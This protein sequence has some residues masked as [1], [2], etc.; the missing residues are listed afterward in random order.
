MRAGLEAR[1]HDPLWMLARQWQLGEFLGTDGGSPVIARFRAEASRLDR[2]LRGWPAGDA[3]SAAGEYRSR[4]FPLEALVEREQV[5]NG[6][7]PVLRLAAE[8]GLHFLRLLKRQGANEATR[9]AFVKGYPLRKPTEDQLD[10]DTARFRDVI[11]G[12]V[13]DAIALYVAMRQAGNPGEGALSGLP[14]ELQVKQPAE[15]SRVAHAADE[16]ISWYGNLFS[17]PGDERSAWIPER[18][19]YGFAVSARTAEGEVVLA[20]REY[21][22]GHLD[23][24]S[25]NLE[26]AASLGTS[27][28]SEREP[29]VAT[30]IPAPVGFRGMP[31]ARWWEFEDAQIDLG[32]VEAEPEDVARLLLVEFAIIYGNDWFVMPVE[33]PVGSI[34]RPRSL[35]VIDT[36]GQRT[37]IRPYTQVDGVESPWRVFH[38]SPDFFFLPPSLAASLQSPP[39]EEV[40]LMRDEMANMAWAVERVIESPAGR[41]VRRFEEFQQERELQRRERERAGAPGQP[42]SGLSLAYR[43]ASSV[44]PHWIPLMPERVDER[45]IRLRRGTVMQPDGSPAPIRPKGRILEPD[46]ALGLFEEEVSRAGVRITR[47]YQYA[48]W[49]DGTSHL[50]VARRKQPGRGE[51]SSGLRFDIVEPV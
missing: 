39:T 48:R 42:A 37:L 46:R 13:P 10:R 49:I 4:E 28:A 44:P 51:G 15:R 38:V 21:S 30:S 50:W 26:A 6:Q 7:G 23:W 47:A 1:V 33:L 8:A 20:A 45:S 11:A 25:F 29:V 31:A 34:C 19:E 9:A 36:F 14:L 22:E 27:P 5:R 24:H 2:F 32:A 3:V 40:L 41:R 18:M 17:E 12:R 35:I 16:W 43:L